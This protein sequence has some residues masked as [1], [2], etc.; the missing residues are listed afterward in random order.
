MKKYGSWE[1]SIIFAII[2]IVAL[3]GLVGITILTKGIIWLFFI[4]TVIIA[5]LF[6]YTKL[7]AWM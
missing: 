3:V 4:P 1:D 6:R 5:L 7:G 2:I